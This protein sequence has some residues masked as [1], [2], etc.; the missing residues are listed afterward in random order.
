ME[1]ALTQR[2]CPSCNFGTSN[3]AFRKNGYSYVRCTNC[4]TTYINPVPAASVL[5]ELYDSLGKDYFTDPRQLILDFA[6]EKYIKE[7]AFL[8]RVYT[9]LQPRTMS[10]ERL[11]EVGCATGSFLIAAQQLGFAVVQGIDIS[12]PAI[13]YAQNL[14]LDVVTGDFITTG[15]LASGSYDVIAMWS[16]LE[17]L[18]DPQAFVGRAYD[19][20][21]PKGLLLTCVPNNK[22]LT[23]R[24][25]GARSRQV[26][27]LHLNYFTASSLTRLF[28]RADFQV[29]CH[30]TMG[31]NP[32]AIW[33]D[34]RRTPVSVERVI[35]DCQR[36]HTIRSSRSLAPVRWLH[37]CIDRV[38]RWMGA[39]ELLLMAGQKR[40]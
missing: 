36:M 23:A 39:G 35:S 2:R 15:R 4:D 7:I 25:L 8:R 30:E 6:P 32:L 34:L 12:E 5:T 40:V 28:T 22:S 17:H 13:Q 10:G 27:L 18:P 1:S 16:L 33:S 26:G 19:L 14:G 11:L 3:Q 31:I 24:L 38:L 29:T 20:L 9:R 37:A 21:A